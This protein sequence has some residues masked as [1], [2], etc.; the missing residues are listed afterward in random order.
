M[1]GPKTSH[2][3]LTPEQ[4]RILREQQE[5]QRKIETEKVNIK[6][7]TFELQC[8][9]NELEKSLPKAQELNS[10]T[11]K[12]NDYISSVNNLIKATKNIL[13]SNVDIS[14]LSQLESQRQ[15]IADCLKNTKVEEA[16]LKNEATA[17]AQALKT[18]LNENIDKGFSLSF[19][20]KINT[21]SNE[22][23]NALI[24]SIHERLTT[25]INIA[26]SDALSKEVFV[27]I[28]KLDKVESLD[29]AQ[30]FNSVVA[31]PLI[32]RC[33]QYSSEY[34]ANIDR[35]NDLSARYQV[36]CND[37]SI[38]YT[39]NPFSLSEMAMLE[40]N[41]VT[42]ETQYAEQAENEYITSSID[43]VMVE[44]GYDVLGSKEVKKRNGSHFRSEL[45]KFGEGTAVN[46]TYSS[47]GKII[48]ELGGVSHTDRVATEAEK[49]KLCGDMET[50][51][52]D[53]KEIEKCLKDRGVVVK[54]RLS[55]CPPDEQYVQIINVLDYSINKEIEEIAVK[56]EKSKTQN[57]KTMGRD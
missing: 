52:T 38:D 19:E 17:I 11:G 10:R 4:R 5:R 3:T 33:K 43:A 8:I 13:N 40:K 7:Y 48:M 51:C 41:I 39:H 53:F 23:L 28:E 57:Q 32:K 16:N 47:D 26:L 2:Y 12:A 9:C 37:L 15:L 20:Q 6:R 50:F 30:N 25:L 29:F 14:D 56:R 55:I 34:D 42:L 31:T 46:V 22:E 36:L 45:Y 18:D 24:L 54:D 1:S 44:M 49:Q 21:N 27:A 35:Y